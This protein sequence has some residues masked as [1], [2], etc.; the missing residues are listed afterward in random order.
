M[1][2]LSYLLIFIVFIGAGPAFAA[3]W[4]E[5]SDLSKLYPGYKTNYRR[6][7][8]AL[9]VKRVKHLVNYKARE[10]LDLLSNKTT[11]IEYIT[12]NCKKKTYMKDRRI[13]LNHQNKTVED[14]FGDEEFKPVRKHLNFDYMYFCSPKESK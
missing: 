11:F 10:E 12:L 9:S 13:A 14:F 6:Y 8:D 4:I 1:R 7:I 2:V 3:R 5:V